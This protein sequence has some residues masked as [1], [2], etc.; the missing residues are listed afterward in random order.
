MSIDIHGF[1]ESRVVSRCLLDCLELR[2]NREKVTI[3][4]LRKK[5]M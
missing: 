4:S 2:D 3:K 5:G 1:M